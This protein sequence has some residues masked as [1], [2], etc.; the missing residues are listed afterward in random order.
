MLDP[1]TYSRI[2]KLGT[3]IIEG[4]LSPETLNA[5]DSYAVSEVMASVRS[6]STADRVRTKLEAVRAAATAYPAVK[7]PKVQVVQGNGWLVVM[8]S[9]IIIL[10][11][12]PY[13]FEQLLNATNVRET[14]LEPGSSKVLVSILGGVS[15]PQLRECVRGDANEQLKTDLK[16]IRVI[17]NI[18]ARL[19]QSMTVIS[20]PDSPSG[21]G[22]PTTEH[23]LLS[24]LFSRIGAVEYLPQILMDNGASLCTSTTA[25]FASLIEAV[26]K[27]DGAAAIDARRGDLQNNALRMAAYAARGAADLILSGQTPAEII[28]QV[29]T[30][31]GATR[32]G[33]N[34]F[35]EVKIS[36]LINDAMRGIFQAAGALGV[37]KQS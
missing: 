29:A 1:L 18:A 22:D 11:C 17:P 37:G 3:A 33:L 15:I 23:V 26:G 2:G 4:L 19:G 21:A 27:S 6:E 32:K 30:P 9:D 34:K 35:N 13:D 16:I 31:G 14:L 12:K 10:G 36:V 20:L 8:Q 24:Q 5:S 25:L 28:S 7:F